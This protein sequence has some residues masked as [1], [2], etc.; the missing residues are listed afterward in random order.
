MLALLARVP[1]GSD[2]IK[3]TPIDQER[4]L[5][6]GKCLPAPDRDIGISRID[7]QAETAPPGRL[8]RDQGRAAAKE[9]VVNRLARAAVIDDR[10]A[11]AFDRLLGA[12]D[13][14]GILTAA[15]NSPKR[16]LL[17]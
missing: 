2:R 7:L 5:L 3:T 9:R 6:A 17:A 12:V 15:G 11:H 16:R 14:F 10:P 4:G 8:P 13:R 1:F